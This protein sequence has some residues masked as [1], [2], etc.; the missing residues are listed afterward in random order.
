MSDRGPRQEGNLGRGLAHQV[1]L[2]GGRGRCE[3][4]T[5][6]GIRRAF[7]EERTARQGP[8]IGMTRNV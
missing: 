3:A 4:A 7:L 2:V 6:T 5:Q 1:T 8:E